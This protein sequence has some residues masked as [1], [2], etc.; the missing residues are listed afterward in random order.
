[1]IETICADMEVKVIDLKF[2]G[3]PGVIAAFLVSGPDGNVLIE[4][5][6]ES[7]RPALLEALCGHG[8]EARDLAGVF[9]TH[10]HLDHAGAAGWFAGQGVPVF[11]HEKGARHLI[12]PSRLIESA[13]MVYGARFD[14]LW[15]AMAPAPEDRVQA[16]TD[17]EVVHL[18]GLR[19]EVIATPGHAFHHHAYSIGRDLFSGDAAGARL[20]E[21]NYLSVTSAPPQ[22]DLP[23]TIASIERLRELCPQRLFLTHFG[24]VREPDAHL[25]AYRDAVDMNVEF[26]RQR[27]A[28]GFDAA[29]LQVAYEAFQLEQAFR[30]GVSPEQWRCYEAV[31]GA[32]M[33]AE[34]IR[35]YWVKRREE[36]E[37]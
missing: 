18:A 23:H 22:F 1:M 10:I 29:S 6:P 21:S 13:R 11:V 15:G 28:E 27:M 17:G 7:T 12:D 31:N 14:A 4:T 24:I 20:G 37:S 8:V 3:I 36:A 35:L 32:A 19:I 16:L 33:C 2:Q 9:V 34:G 25:L 26:I 30:L 5:G